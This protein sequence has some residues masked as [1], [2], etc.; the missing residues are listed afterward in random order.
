MLIAELESR[1]EDVDEFIN[2]VEG[3]GFSLSKKDL[4]TQYFYFFDFIKVSNI[5]NQAHLK[6]IYLKPYTYK[7]R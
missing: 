2:S 6:N 1:F 7:K 5:K 3:Y 4:K